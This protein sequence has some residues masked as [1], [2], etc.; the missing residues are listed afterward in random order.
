MKK[1]S[2][3]VPDSESLRQLG[4]DAVRVVIDDDQNL[5]HPGHQQFRTVSGN[6]EDEGGVDL[7]DL[8][9]R[10]DVLRA[11]A[12]T[13][14]GGNA[15]TDHELNIDHLFSETNRAAV[16]DME[17]FAVGTEFPAGSVRKQRPQMSVVPLSNAA[18]LPITGTRVSPSAA[19]GSRSGTDCDVRIIQAAAP[20]P[21]TAYPPPQY[22]PAQFPAAYPQPAF[23][24]FT[25][26]PYYQQFQ[27]SGF[28]PTNSV[29][30][31]TPVAPSPAV[32][33]DV[34]AENN[35]KNS[36][37]GAHSV[38]HQTQATTSESAVSDV[39]TSLTDDITDPDAPS[40]ETPPAVAAPAEVT[41][42]EA[43]V[44]EP[45]VAV[46]PS[47]NTP[48]E[49]AASAAPAV[50]DEDQQV[51]VSAEE[52]QRQLRQAAA[53]EAFEAGLAEVLKTLVSNATVEEEPAVPRILAKNI[54]RLEKLKP[55]DT[56]DAVELIHIIARTES[57]AAVETLKTYT[58]PKHPKV[59]TA[60]VEGLG[61]IRHVRSVLTLIR[62]L[63]DPQSDVVA[64]AVESLVRTGTTEMTGPLLCLSIARPNVAAALQKA[65]ETLPDEDRPAFIEPLRR[66][67]KHRNAA[68]AAT[69]LRLLA[70]ISGAELSDQCMKLAA[71]HPQAEVRAA[72]VECLG[73]FGRK[74]SVS[75]L[76]AAMQDPEPV[77]RSAAASAMAALH[78]PK[79]IQLLIRGLTDSEQTV[80]RHC[81]KTLTE[82][83]DERIA[84]AASRAVRQQTDAPTIEYLLEIIGRG[85]TDE[86]LVTLQKF[87]LGDDLQFRHR[88]L[89]TLR[90]LKNPKSLKM[91][92]P[93]L[94]DANQ[95]TREL[96]VRT[97]GVLGQNSVAPKLRELLKSDK[98][99]KVR[100]A[101]AR[102]LGELKDPKSILAL[103][104]ALHDDRLVAA[105][106]VVALGLTGQ[107]AAVPA[108]IGQLRNPASDIR[109][110]ACNALAEIG[111][112]PNSGPLETLLDDREATVRKAAESALEKLGMGPTA[113]QKSLRVVRKRA[114]VA[115]GYL[116]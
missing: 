80:R 13:Q 98:D 42:T 111:Q 7:S 95:T 57:P 58:G 53:L 91:V 43:A 109:Y 75:R 108:L 86:A 61:H 35:R 25:G 93:F 114:T 52:L 14:S 47:A 3:G 16:N 5:Y 33:G 104:E 116:V 62:L 27:S 94:E 19:S 12:P 44:A 77:V 112:L 1:V 102:S 6:D 81:A 50:P 30:P 38:E 32:T 17:D 106:A 67:L 90:R 72:A 105:Q 40:D 41:P 4:G 70:K 79:S 39:P 113:F 87:L 101:A 84:P 88:A 48:H 103:E 26:H 89:N 85:G 54:S 110:H 99:V 76:N 100:A 60:A 59:R 96:A 92:V 46:D 31:P 8:L 55:G 45:Q 68:T 10:S 66:E 63:K 56:D 28:P 20:L 34:A 107:K 69:A 74:Q 36:F 115:A 73:E 51:R 97:V 83:D 22:P 24:P 71:R 9:A 37:S 29:T 23:P 18:P 49:Q 82:I 65:F 2:G 78:S 15:D 64:A 11:A 21:P